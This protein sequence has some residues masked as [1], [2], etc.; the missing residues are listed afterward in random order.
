MIEKELIVLN[1]LGLHARSAA[2]LVK[3]AE[4]FKSS[5]FIFKD[6]REVN[7]KS[8][9]GL[10]LLAAEC[11]SKLIVRISGPDERSAMEAIGR[12]FRRHFDEDDCS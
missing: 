6:G 12:L 7:A 8:V 1:K 10:L 11:G 2:T 4:K 3:E 9:M 5:I